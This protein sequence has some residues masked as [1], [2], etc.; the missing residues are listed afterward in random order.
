MTFEDVVEKL[1]KCAA[2]S[3]KPLSHDKLDAFLNHVKTLEQV[4]DARC[5]VPL[6]F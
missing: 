1:W 6:L 2:F 4:A 5:L 3:V